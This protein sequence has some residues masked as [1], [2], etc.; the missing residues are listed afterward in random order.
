ML[1]DW[2]TRGA[3]VFSFL[4][5]FHLLGSLLVE[6]V[7]A[8]L[9]GGGARYHLPLAWIRTSRVNLGR[10]GCF[11]ED[12]QRFFRKIPSVQHALAE[13]HPASSVAPPPLKGRCALSLGASPK[14]AARMSSRRDSSEASCDC[15]SCSKGRRCRPSPRWKPELKEA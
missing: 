10:K 14:P 5:A 7:E 13:G 11:P 6:N 3:P 8:L 12:R 1:P 9:H 2:S 15:L 4:Q